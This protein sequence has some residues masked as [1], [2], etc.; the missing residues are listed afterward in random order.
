[1]KRLLFSCILFIYS[2]SSVFSQGSAALD[3]FEKHFEQAVLYDQVSLYAKC[4]KEIYIALQITKEQKWLKREVTA[5]IF[6]AELKRKAEDFKEGISILNGLRNAVN[7]PTFYVE[8]LGRIA[9][10]LNE[11]ANQVRGSS[12]I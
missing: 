6:L 10:L 5:G 12:K 4:I 2:L 11:E 1:M 9:A 8:K 3:A 7:F